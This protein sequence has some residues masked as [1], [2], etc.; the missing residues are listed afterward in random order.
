MGLLTRFIKRADDATTSNDL[1]DDVVLKALLSGDDIDATKAMTIPA[2][3]SAVNRIAAPVYI[4]NL[5][6]SIDNITFSTA[7]IPITIGQV[8]RTAAG[9][10]NVTVT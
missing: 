5:E 1:V 6:M 4:V 8:A 10:I 9:F 3:A 2:V 7:T